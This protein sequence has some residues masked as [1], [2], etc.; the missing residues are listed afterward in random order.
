MN[1]GKLTA[2]AL[3]LVGLI[4]PGCTSPPPPTPEQ[5]AMQKQLLETIMARRGMAPM[6]YQ[7]QA[8]PQEP[9]VTLTEDDLAK[10]FETWPAAD[11]PVQFARKKDGFEINGKHY[12]DPEGRIVSYGYD[13]LNGDVTYLVKTGSDSG[14]LKAIRALKSSAPIKI[15]DVKKAGGTWTATTVTGQKLSGDVLVPMSRGVVVLRDVAGFLYK[16][17]SPV[18][19]ITM[20]AGFMVAAYQNGDVLSTRYILAER[21]PAQDGT[22][23]LLGTVQSLGSTLGVNKKEDYILVN[24]DSGQQ[25]PLNISIEDKQVTVHKNCRRTKQLAKGPVPVYNNECATID[26]YDSLFEPDGDPHYSH[27]FWRVS[28][29]KARSGVLLVAKEGGFGGTVTV[30]NLST[31][32]QAVAFQRA[33]GLILEDVR[34][35]QDGK[36][37]LTARMGFTRETVDDA[38]TLLE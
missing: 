4:E 19:S 30:T 12:V 2:F 25:V 6:P 10:Q 28:W 37:S 15:A 26:T 27:Y 18:Q 9:K 29:I 22:G 16:P 5:M 33:L 1:S 3:V 24:I 13:G 7:M 23:K 35:I 38:E 8:A 36:V 21:E 11:Q 20:P 32:K 34:Q 14:V 31:G 17:G